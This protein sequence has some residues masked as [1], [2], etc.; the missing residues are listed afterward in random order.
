MASR[1]V[2]H[3]GEESESSADEAYSDNEVLTSADNDEIDTSAVPAASCPPTSPPATV[4]RK[5]PA[6]RSDRFADSLLHQ[7][8]REANI[9]LRN[10]IKHQVT[11]PYQ[12]ATKN[13][14][15][16]TYSLSKIQ[17]S[18]SEV[19]L[20]LQQIRDDLRATEEKTSDIVS[21]DFLVDV[22]I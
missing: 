21:S 16:L 8:L 12:K 15:N 19:C 10:S 9:N 6:P 3:P 14:Q 7:K 1:S 18:M 20:Q 5:P 13:V 11:A 4:P 2:I 17:A 22:K